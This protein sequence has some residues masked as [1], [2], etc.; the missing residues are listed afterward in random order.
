M[1]A[2]SPS[3]LPSLSL[4]GER[5][6]CCVI[7]NK[8]GPRSIEFIGRKL[9]SPLGLGQSERHVQIMGTT[10][11]DRRDVM[12]GER[13]DDGVSAAD[14]FDVEVP[15]ELKAHAPCVA[16]CPFDRTRMP[17][18]EESAGVLDGRFVGGCV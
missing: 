11:A 3:M 15:D 10:R 1:R 14:A 12:N 13:A 9:G 5:G 7:G 4:R 2:A 6:F 8:S 16:S 17:R 18:D